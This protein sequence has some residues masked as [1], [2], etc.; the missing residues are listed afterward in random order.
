MM[1]VDFDNRALGLYF[2][3]GDPDDLYTTFDGISL[4]LNP[5]ALQPL[6]CSFSHVK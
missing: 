3:Q 2:R 1:T 6:L 4:L 5:K